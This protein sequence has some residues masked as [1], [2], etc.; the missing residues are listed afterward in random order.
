MEKQYVRPEIKVAEME[1]CTPLAGS[2][3]TVDMKYGGEDDHTDDSWV[4]AELAA[5]AARAQP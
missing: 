3:D 1:P 2:T 5:N 4:D